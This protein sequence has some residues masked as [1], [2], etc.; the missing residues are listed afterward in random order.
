MLRVKVF[1]TIT[2]WLSTVSGVIQD[3]ISVFIMLQIFLL[4]KCQTINK[5]MNLAAFWGK[6]HDYHPDNGGSMHL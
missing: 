6:C 2:V 4:F 5:T 3:T 1:V